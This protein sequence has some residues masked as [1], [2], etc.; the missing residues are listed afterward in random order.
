MILTLTRQAALALMQGQLN[1]WLQLDATALP[2]LAAL[3]DSVVR[4]SSH[5][6]PLEL[7]L[8]PSGDGLR[9]T[10][11]PYGQVVCQAS[12]PIEAW[13]Q[14]ALT[15]D[16][17]AQLDDPRLHIE[18]DRSVFEALLELLGSLEPDWCYSLARRL[19]PLGGGLLER[20]LQDQQ[21]G[22]QAHQQSLEQ[23]IDNYL[24]RELGALVS[25][26]QG[27]ARAA[28]IDELAARTQRLQQRL[29]Q[30]ANRQPG[31]GE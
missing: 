23:D 15:R 11:A 9:L 2:R 1:R 25:R 22:H 6:P 4:I 31:S 27:D 24:T 19:G 20:F 17:S 26:Q 10:D 12:G 5:T 3:G 28:Q 18:G 29:E 7:Y 8:Q 14:L 16:K 30:L 13:L 21:Q